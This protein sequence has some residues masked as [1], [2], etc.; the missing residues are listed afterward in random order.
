M[1]IR[2]Y[3]QGD[4]KQVAQLLGD[5]V[6]ILNAQ[7]FSETEIDSFAP[8]HIH[9]KEWEE[10]CLTNFTVVAESNYRI[11]GIG[12]IEPN[13]HINCF[14]CHPDNRGQNIGRQLYTTLEEYAKA[15]HIPVI[16]TET[17]AE[18]RPFYFKMGFTTVQKQK[19]LLQGSIESTFILE[20]QL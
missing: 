4:I 5:S 17:N 19:V 13:G 11:V 1:E 10:S 14:Y 20:K 8:N 6:S 3:Q 18:D 9:L 12:Q 16:H 15:K 2:L 7:G